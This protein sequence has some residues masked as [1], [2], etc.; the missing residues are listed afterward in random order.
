MWP[1][2]GENWVS[3]IITE[4]NTNIQNIAIKTGDNAECILN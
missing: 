4:T 2:V 1:G 3:I